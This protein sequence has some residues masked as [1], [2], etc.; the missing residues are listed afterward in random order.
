[1]VRA[2]HRV[3]PKGRKKAEIYDYFARTHVRHTDREWYDKP[4][5]L[6]KWQWE[7]IW[8]PVFGTLKPDGTRRYRQALIGVKRYTGKSEIS[9]RIML[10]VMMMEPMP[11]GEYGIIASSKPQAQIVFD[12]I[13]AMVRLDPELSAVFEV[14]KKEI[15]HRETGATLST[16]PADEAAIQGHHFVCCIGDEAH[17]WKSTAIFSAIVSGMKDRNSL[18]II[19]TTAG[20]KRRGVLWDYIIPTMLANPDAYVIWKGAQTLEEQLAGAKFDPADRRLWR[21]CVFASWHTMQQMEELHRTLPLAEF[22]RYELNVFPPDDLG[23]DM[24][25]KPSR[26]KRCADAGEFP[27]DAPLSMGID[28]ANSGDSFALVIAAN[29][30]ENSSVVRAYPIIFDEAGEDGF[31]DIEQIEQL[32]REYYDERDMRRIAMDPARLLLMAQHLQK[33]WGV[34][35]ESFA[36]SGS[37]MGAASAYLLTLVDEGRLRIHGPDSAKLIEHMTNATRDDA[38]AWGWRLGKTASRAKIDGCIALAIAALV[39]DANDD[40]AAWGLMTV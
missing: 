20:S 39:L 15:R 19:I 23:A 18:F 37:N 35:V 24:A 29:D 7:D 6:D 27:W 36:Q 21:K 34:P 3:T 11:E 4:F 30:P 16:Y 28:G 40:G 17:V 31:Y 13:C 5:L 1:M 10:T 26:V 32:V 22:V 2:R 33:K 8:K 12:K 38:G 14:L 9:A 25:F